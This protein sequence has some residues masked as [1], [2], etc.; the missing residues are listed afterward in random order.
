MASGEAEARRIRNRTILTLGAVAAVVAVLAVLAHQ[1][2]LAEEGSLPR[3]SSPRQITTASEVED[4]PSWRPDATQVVYE[5][6]QSGNWDI[7]VTQV[8]G[9]GTVNLTE[10]HEGED[11]FPSWSLRRKPDRLLLRS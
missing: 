6:Y 7:W 2:W 3:L 4:Y 11:R 1:F 8:S 10:D 9:G 5:S